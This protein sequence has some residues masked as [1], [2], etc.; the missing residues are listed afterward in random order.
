MRWIRAAVSAGTVS[1]LLMTLAATQA[2][3]RVQQAPSSRVAIDLPDGY[4]PSRLFTGFV[5]EAAGVS[6][7]IVE[8]PE[9]AYEQLANGLTPEALATKG[10]TDVQAGK[11]AR[12]EPYIYMTGVQASGQGPVAKFLM[13]FRNGGVT[14]LITANVQKA[15]LDQG[16]L[17]AEDVERFLASAKIAA[18]A[19][20]AH[21]LFR[22]GYLG[23]FKPAGSILGTTRAFTLDGRMEPGPP[24]EQRTVLI[25]APSLDLR[26]VADAERQAEV[27]LQGLAGLQSP[28]VEERRR[29]RVADM[30]AIELVGSATDKDGGTALG[31]WQLLVLP[32]RGGYYRLVGQ[33]PLADKDA[34]L[35]ELRR[36][37]DGFKPVQ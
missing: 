25:V 31:L 28:K 11:I 24:G 35:P 34:L 22:L 10:I 32:A 1:L 20:P 33:M 30:D 4:Q 7:V 23:P 12:A 27:L 3:A 13:A 5:N 26:P 16:M 9:A 2:T 8:L 21:E 18:A 17:K 29:L 15:S 19:A 6:L 36:I 37:A 14:A